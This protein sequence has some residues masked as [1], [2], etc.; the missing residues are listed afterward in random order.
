MGLA[1]EPARKDAAYKR[2]VDL[3]KRATLVDGHN[4]LPWVI[5]NANGG[6][7]GAYDLTRVHAES[8]T[9]IPR[10]KAG[11]VGV[12][13]LAAYLPSEIARPATVTVEQIDLI[14][15]IEAR[16]KDVFHP[17]RRATGHPCR[18]PRQED[19][20][21][22]RRGRHG[23]LRGLARAGADVA[24]AWRQAGDAL[25]QRLPP[26]GR[27]LDRH[28]DFGSLSA[29][30]LSLVAELNRLGMIV[31]LSHAS[32]PAALAAVEASRAPVVLS[33]SNA[34]ALCPHPRNAPDDLIRAV[35][36]KGGIVMA[37]FVPEFINAERF[38]RVEA[39][40]K[41]W[42]RHAPAAEIAA[43]EKAMAAEGP[44]PP[45]TLDQFCVHVE[46][47]LK[48]V[49]PDHVGIGSDFF[50]GEAVVG[51]EDVSAFPALFAALLRRGHPEHVLA[52][53]AGANFIR[54][55]RNVERVGRQMEREMDAPKPARATRKKAASPAGAGASAKAAPAVAIRRR[56]PSVPRAPRSA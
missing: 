20:H 44:L 24:P 34:H 7:L 18:S 43:I 51:L 2:A 1:T 4:D 55:M 29:F 25:P 9:D 27:F 21:A 14:R 26:L 31:D 3:L 6:D 33:H 41:A 52:R 15:R 42:W 12:Q 47:L 35:A 28:A 50:G 53:V 10:L 30:G 17:I 36:A 23:R 11:L 16:H 45:A 32:V 49:G 5:R 22:D 48:L 56:S 39:H 46:H 19:R 54:V 13:V 8:D 38:K 40:R 37:T